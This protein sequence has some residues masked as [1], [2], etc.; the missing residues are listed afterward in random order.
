MLAEPE[1]GDR[2][3]PSEDRQL[4]LDALL[5]ATEHLVITFE[6]RDQHLNQRRPPAVPVAELLDVVDKTVRLTDPAGRPARWWW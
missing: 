4:L 1:V 2:D 3:V 5:A 6:G